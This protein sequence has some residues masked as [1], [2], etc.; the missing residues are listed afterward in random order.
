MT[1]RNPPRGQV[2][3]KHLAGASPRR[4]HRVGPTGNYANAHRQDWHQKR[5]GQACFSTT[6]FPTTTATT[7]SISWVYLY[8]YAGANTML[9]SYAATTGDGEFYTIAATATADTFTERPAWWG[10]DSRPNPERRQVEVRIQGSV[11]T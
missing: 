11:R 1:D 2:W 8:I 6:T 4:P 3:V 10:T 5:F 9:T 7:T